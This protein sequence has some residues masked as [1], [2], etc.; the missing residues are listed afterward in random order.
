MDIILLIDACTYN[1]YFNAGKKFYGQIIKNNFPL[2]LY[3]VFPLS[4]IASYVSFFFL[5]TP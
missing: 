1:N 5:V 3:M 2:L 4:L